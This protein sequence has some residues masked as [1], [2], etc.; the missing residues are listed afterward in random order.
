[1]HRPSSEL[2]FGIIGCGRVVQELHLPAWQLIPEARLVAICDANQAALQAVSTTQPEVRHY[3]T[4]EAFLADAHDLNFVVLAT[5]GVSHPTIGEQVLRRK[6]HLLCEKPLA[7][8][9]RDAEHLFKVADEEGVVLTPIHNYRYRDTVLAAR[10]RAAQGVLG[11]IVSVSVR[12]RS[13]SL[14][15]EPATWMRQERLHRTLLFDFAYHFV[16]LALLF[17]GPIDSLRFVEAEMDSVGLQSVVFGTLH[18]H[19]ARGFFE[20][21]LDASCCRTEIE[22]LGESCGLALDFFPDGFRMLPRRDTPLHRGIADARRCFQ[23][24]LYRVKQ[25]LP[26]STSYHVLPHAGLF[27]AFVDALRREGAN[28]VPRAEVL[29][30]LSLLSGVA[31]RAYST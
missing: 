20:L 13:G 1:M 21:M 28:P 7:L 16:D 12:F 11:D 22:V 15:D 14:F 25:S 18:K 24:A 17:L 31:E 5:P 10:G 27:R 3:T 4:V 23:F 6:L 30:T 29:Q 19:G 8:S 2:A 9:T 26:R